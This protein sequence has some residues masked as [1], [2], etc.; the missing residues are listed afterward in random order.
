M[1]KV[2]D[3]TQVGVY[4]DGYEFP[5]SNG[6]ALTVLHIVAS[7][8]LTLP[9]LH[10]QIMDSL[11]VMK[12]TNLND[13]SKLTV[14]IKGAQTI[15]RNF[16]VHHWIRTPI[17][18]GFTYTIDAYYDAPQYWSGS[19]IG[20]ITDTSSNVLSS[21]CDTTGL[22]YW[23]KNTSTK[24]SMLWMPSN[25]SYGLWARAIARYGYLND[26]SHMVL[27]VDTQGNMRYIDVN[28]FAS[29][30]INVGYLAPQGVD[31]FI[32]I[33]DFKPTVKSG[34]NNNLA[35]YLHTR[36]VQSISN[37][38]DPES[39][40]SVNIGNNPYPLF[41]QDVRST[42]G[43]GSISYSPIDVGNTHDKYE[44]ARYQNSRYDM[45]NNLGGEFLFPVQNNLEV[46]DDFSYTG[47]AGL[48]NIQY[49]GTY[50]IGTK[51]IFI[52]GSTYQ[53]KVI[54][55]RLGLNT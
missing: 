22:T 48:H 34:I 8:T 41:N 27:G 11:N 26:T 35:G 6:N 2:N 30:G 51:I 16:R 43:R 45:L 31:N 15:T 23:P 19:A 17:G 3:Y 28:S 53:E 49:D 38:T 14:V 20:G 1:F 42:I 50:R 52:A 54:A 33:T 39:E 40:L 4:I 29:S 37:G 7:T 24:D 12:D 44:R 55:F 9:A 10:I 13:G 5:L 47:P 18:P 32:T 36:N 21:I 46:L 25:K